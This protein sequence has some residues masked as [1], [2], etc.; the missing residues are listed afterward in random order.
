MPEEPVY[1]HSTYTFNTPRLTALRDAR[2]LVLRLMTD[3][4]FPSEGFA[5]L[6]RIWNYLFDQSGAER[7]GL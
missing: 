7:S 4:Q 6:E 2:S 5:K 1:P 3:I